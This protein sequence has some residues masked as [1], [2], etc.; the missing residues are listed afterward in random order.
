MIRLLAVA[1]RLSPVVL[2]FVA[3]CGGSPAT[4]PAAAR[5]SGVTLAQKNCAE[6]HDPGDGSYSGRTMTIVAGAEVFPRNLTPDPDTGIS[7]WTV[8]QITG[9]IRNGTDDQGMPLCHVMPHFAQLTDEEVTA[10]VTF[11]KGLP[12]VH[13]MI[14]DTVCP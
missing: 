10:I 14:P 2:A 4:S 5:S 3:G 9:A 11:L 1:R 12:P 7:T 8:E 6:C 13:K